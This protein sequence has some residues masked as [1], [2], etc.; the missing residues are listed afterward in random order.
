MKHTK[1][2][3]IG[4]SLC[5]LFINGCAGSYYT[6]GRRSGP[7]FYHSSYS[8]GWGRGHYR[9]MDT[10]RTIDTINTIDTIDTINTID[11]IDTIDTIGG[12]DRGMGGMG[13]MG[14]MDMGM[15]DFD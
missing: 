2:Y 7:T 9:A 1:I 10:A 3:F 15:P 4:I 8:H 12:M 11:T 6:D 5:A 13:G 14:G